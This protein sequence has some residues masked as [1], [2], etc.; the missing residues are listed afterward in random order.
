MGDAGG[1]SGPIRTMWLLSW[2]TIGL[3]RLSTA[4][5]PQAV[6]Q[7]VEASG[8]LL[9]TRLGRVAL[10]EMDILEN[11]MI[12]VDLQLLQLRLLPHTLPH[13]LH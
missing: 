7:W 10:T 6:S 3:A 1:T 13:P 9:R 11:L 2:T 8:L 4:N 5:H 12:R